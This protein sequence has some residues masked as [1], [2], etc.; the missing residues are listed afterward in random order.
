MSR[1]TACKTALEV[2]LCGQHL[3]D[4][5]LFSSL[6]SAPLPS[7]FPEILSFFPL[8]TVAVVYLLVFFPG[9]RSCSSQDYKAC[10]DNWLDE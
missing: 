10:Q 1:E 3:L 4:V 8:V 5:G 7:S 2:C 9:L 6:T